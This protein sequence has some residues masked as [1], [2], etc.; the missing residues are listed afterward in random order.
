MTKS[1]NRRRANE[2]PERKS[3]QTRHAIL[4][5]AARI[6]RTEGFNATTM[7]QIAEAAAIQAGSIYYHFA[8]KDRIL[9]EVIDLGLHSLYDNVRRRLE[10]N[11]DDRGQFREILA[12]LIDVHLRFLLHENDYLLVNTKNYWTMAQSRR[13]YHRRL[14]EAYARLWRGFLQQARDRGELRQD[15]SVILVSQFILGAM[16]WTIEWYDTDRYPINQLSERVVKLLLDGMCI[17]GGE[18]TAFSLPLRTTNGDEELRSKAEV[19]RYHILRA[20]ARV[21]RE[22]G[23]RAATM[24]QV[25]AEAGIEAGSMYYHFNSKGQLLD[26]VLDL[27]V[28]DLLH[29]VR[30]AIHDFDEAGNHDHRCRI[31]IA[32]E[33]HMAYLFRAS[34]FTSANIR[35]YGMLPEE[36]RRRHRPIRHEYARLW[37][38][39]LREAQKAGTLR[40]DIKV[41]PLR[42]FML[43]ALNW[44]IEWFDPGKAGRPGHHT[45]S[46]FAHQITT[47]L[48][49]GISIASPALET[50]DS[51][52]MAAHTSKK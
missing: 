9:D 25:A 2:A 12:D 20:A 6:F 8:S 42:Q 27:G 23:Y 14:R 32:I 50:V 10:S 49:D 13:R 4:A 7:R 46:A 30:R 22:R 26:E 33:M 38:Q 3:E 16:N 5:A 41:V 35:I 1:V 18:T 48:L 15:I 37:D 36:I 29:G 19:T 51:S 39:I 28:R 34:E 31:S 43:G 52:Q 45:L 21:L 40:S 44:T 47:L 17:K 11:D 24:R